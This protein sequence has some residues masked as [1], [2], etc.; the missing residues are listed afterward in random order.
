M[1]IFRQPCVPVVALQLVAGYDI[2]MIQKRLGHRDVRTTMVYT[3]VLNQGGPGVRSPRDQLG[4]SGPPLSPPRG[5]ARARIRAI[6]FR[7]SGRPS[8]ADDPSSGDEQSLSKQIEPSTLPR[9]TAAAVR[10][11]GYRV[12]PTTR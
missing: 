12:G 5:D 2:R 1:T 10:L 7:I 3:H 6:E 11:P 9:Y 8:I 4:P